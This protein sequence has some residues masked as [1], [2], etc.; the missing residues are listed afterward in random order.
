MDDKSVRA[1]YET[2]LEQ[3]AWIVRE[4]FPQIEA[5]AHNG[6]YDLITLAID[7]SVALQPEE[8]PKHFRD[9]VVA[10]NVLNDGERENMTGLKL[11]VK[12]LFNHTMV[13]YLTAS[14]GGKNLDTPRF[15]KYGADDSY[16]QLKLWLHLVPRLKDEGFWDYFTKILMPASNTFVDIDM[17]G[18]GY[19]VD[20][21]LEHYNQLSEIRDSVGQQIMDKVGRVNLSSPPA[22]AKRLYADLGYTAPN[23]P[24]TDKGKEVK[25]KGGHLTYKHYSTNDKAIEKLAKRYP[26]CKLISYHR[27]C[28]KQISTYLEPAITQVANNTSKR[29]HG[30]SNFV[31]STGRMSARNYPLQTIPTFL[32]DYDDKNNP[33]TKIKIREAF[34]PQP[35][36]SLYVSDFSQI[37]L[38]F[39]GLVYNDRVFLDAYRKWVC[40]ACNSKG[41][42]FDIQHSCPECGIAE[43]E[44][45]MS[46]KV[47]GF[48]H[49]LDLHTDLSNDI[50]ALGGDRQ[51]A[52]AA[53]FALIFNATAWTMHINNPKASVD[54]W[55]D[56]IEG[57]FRV[58]PET[59]AYHRKIER[60][61]D[62]T[63]EVRNMFNRR[64]KLTKAEVDSHRKHCINQLV[65]FPVQSAP[66]SLIQL[67][68]SNL[69]KKWMK[70]KIWL[71]SV[72]IVNVVH[73]EIVVEFRKDLDKKIPLDV[74]YEMENAVNLKMPIRAE[75]QIVENWGQAK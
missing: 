72:K 33:F 21:C 3:V 35:G 47:R 52:K 74:Q 24:L 4:L 41:S 10:Y 23:L 6:K 56:I 22:L 66:A 5:T 59:K 19:D 12:K 40:T 36:W 58:H 2:D 54:Q 32:G 68:A 57:F 28:E 1:F 45:A 37:E 13:D 20:K 18:M 44:K 53:N 55:E 14:D 17:A 51:L 25:N 50:P 34:V 39:A 30:S 27:T 73:D 75:G 15:H 65:N 61:V 48:W 63:R 16:W 38:R 46:G 29:I 49:G 64:R 26:V 9:S 69:R 42:S 62:T 31:T 71:N 8:Y 7:K 60:I 43:D 11:I 70:E 67:V